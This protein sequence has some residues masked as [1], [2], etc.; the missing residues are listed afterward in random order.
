MRSPVLKL[1]ALAAAS[2]LLFA[3]CSDD[4]EDSSEAETGGPA[5]TTNLEIADLSAEMEGVTLIDD[6]TLTICSDIPYTPFEFYEDD[7]PDEL[8][9]FDVEIVDGMALALGVETEWVTTPFDGI[10]PSLVAGNC[11]MIGSA[12]TITEERAEQVAFT[13]GY[14]DSEQSLLVRVADEN[15]YTDLESLAGKTI[16][17]QSG[18]T[19]ETY[20][21]ENKPEGATI[22]AFEGGEELFTALTTNDIDAALQDFPVNYVAAQDNPDLV[23][24]ATFP[25]EEQYGFALTQENTALVAA[26]DAALAELRSSGAYDTIYDT[27]FGNA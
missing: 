2:M 9:G 7:N 27:W 8:T 3:A 12:M 19:G 16:G 5:T 25:T 20:A 21:N 26:L 23:I 1:A 22:K 14:F 13:E 11:D 17:V 18:T 6:G 10:I 4:T 15:T 24:T